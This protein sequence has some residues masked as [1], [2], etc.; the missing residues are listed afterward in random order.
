MTDAPAQYNFFIAETLDDGT[1]KMAA[2]GIHVYGPERDRCVSFSR[3]QQRRW[4][5]QAVVESACERA[6]DMVDANLPPVYVEYTDQGRTYR[7]TRKW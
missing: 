7:L 6:M 3:K 2:D 4:I 5:P 1:H